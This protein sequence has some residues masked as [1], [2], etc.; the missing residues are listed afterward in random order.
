MGKGIGRSFGGRGV[1]EGGVTYSPN[2]YPIVALQVAQSLT[3]V[4]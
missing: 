4:V 1:E 2:S 3:L